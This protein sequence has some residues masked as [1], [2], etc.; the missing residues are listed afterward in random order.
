MCR[1]FMTRV[2]AQ[3]SSIKDCCINSKEAVENREK[4]LVLGVGCLRMDTP[5]ESV[6]SANGCSIRTQF[7][8]FFFSFIWS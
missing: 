2:Y 7:P 1:G 4:L 5:Y 6:A 3:A 8:P